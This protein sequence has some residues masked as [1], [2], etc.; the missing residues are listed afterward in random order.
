MGKLLAKGQRARPPKFGAGLPKRS[1]ATD[2][3]SSPIVFRDRTDSVDSQRDK[4]HV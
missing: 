4:S 3:S 1:S 2:V